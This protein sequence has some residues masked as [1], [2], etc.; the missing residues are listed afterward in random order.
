M[1]AIDQVQNLSPLDGRYFS[2]T[3]SLRDYFSEYALIKYRTQVEIEWLL[4]LSESIE[5]DCI[6]PFPQSIVTKLRKIY[7][8]FQPADALKVK[9]I[10]NKTNHDVKAVEYYIAELLEK[11]GFSEAIPMLHFACTSEDINN[12]AYGLMLKHS[13]NNVIIPSCEAL[14]THILEKAENYRHIPLLSKTHGQPASPTT[15]GKEFFNVVARL[16]R[17]INQITN[18]PILGKINGA[19]GN[20]NAHF[21]SYPDV[22]WLSISQKFVESLG[23]SWNPTTTQ[24]EPHDYMAELFHQMAR[25]NNIVLDLDRDIWSYISIGVFKQKPVEG[26]VGSSTMPHKV[27]PIDF[28]NSEGNLGLANAIFDHLATKLPV[29]RWQR[30]LSDST[31]QRNIGVAFAYSILAYQSTL[32]GLGKLAV[33]ERHITAELN[34]AWPVLGEALQTVMRRYKIPDSYEKLKELTRGKQID[35]QAIQNF[36][37][38]LNLPE[39]VKKE[40]LELKPETYI[41]N[42]SLFGKN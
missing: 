16:D 27:N 21:V 12:L 25:W 42:A 5:I 20:F 4:L 35:Q 8:D 11:E 40:L 34:Q 22:D 26:E 33:D 18:Q 37:Q 1:E 24:I 41:G 10:E 13:I 32:K 17:Q 36:I 31:V 3:K 30:D 38:S 23:L 15:L 6:N 19:V 28:E 29:S 14:K 9:T 2:K 39:A 7:Q